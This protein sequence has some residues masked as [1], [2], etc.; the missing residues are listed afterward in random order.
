MIAN[1]ELVGK[2][3]VDPALFEPRSIPIDELITPENTD[4]TNVSRLAES[5]AMQGLIHRIV[6]RRLPRSERPQKSR[7]YLIVSGA[8]RYHALLR[9]DR[10]E[11]PCII[12]RRKDVEYISAG[13][14]LFRKRLDVIERADCLIRFVLKFADQSL[15]GQ[16]VRKPNG[17]IVGL[18]ELIRLLPTNNRTPDARRKE[19]ERA[20]RIISIGSEILDA[21]RNAD[22]HNNQRALL[23]IAKAKPAARL[24]VLS[25][26]VKAADTSRGESATPEV[27]ASATIK[28]N[29][30]R[31]I[32]TK[33]L[34]D[35]TKLPATSLDELSTAWSKSSLPDLWKRA[36]ISVRGE[37]LEALRKKKCSAM[38]DVRDLV[39]EVFRGRRNVYKRELIA[40]AEKKGIRG[41]AVCRMAKHLGYRTKRDGRRGPWMFMNKDP[42]WKE[43]RIA[44]SLTD[45]KPLREQVKEMFASGV[46]KP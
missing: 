4:E 20:S 15:P 8:D 16:V 2:D 11:I 39:V 28:M 14:N 37:F 5:I 30:A 24:K 42:N 38:P 10:A 40:Y 41:K 19:I 32:R 12:C 18:S 44:V 36:P 43:Q 35:A 29:A 17:Q 45:A 34:E 13:E 46:A 22:L 1:Q 27:A 26:L 21:A 31:S 6:V 9:L 33:S 7:K 25:E 3:V 23:R